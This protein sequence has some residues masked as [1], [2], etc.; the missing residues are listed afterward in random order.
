MLKE[1]IEEIRDMDM[2]E[3]NIPSVVLACYLSILHPKL[4]GNVT[5]NV[6]LKDVR[7]PASG[8]V[9]FKVDKNVRDVIRHYMDELML[10]EF[11][12]PLVEQGAGAG[13]SESKLGVEMDTMEMEREDGSVTLRLYSGGDL[14]IRLIII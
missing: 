7:R 13:A 10:G 4:R 6:E 1:E 9:T 14:D 11:E 5:T 2:N 3:G 12:M 8:V